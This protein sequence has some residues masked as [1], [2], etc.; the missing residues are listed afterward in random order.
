MSHDARD[1][2]TDTSETKP[3]PP[4]RWQDD[5]AYAYILAALGND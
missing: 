4:L 1:E 5:Y 2:L 3:K